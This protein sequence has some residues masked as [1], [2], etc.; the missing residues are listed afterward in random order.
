MRL[1]PWHCLALLVLLVLAA[2]FPSLRAGF[3]SVDDLKMLGRFEAGGPLDLVQ[4]FFPQNKRFYYRPL[5]TLTYIFDRDAWGTIPSFM[6]L[7]NILLHLGSTLLVYAVTRRLACVYR[8]AGEAVPFA[9][10]LLFALH[11]LAA[12]PVCWIS[13]RTDL[14]AGLFA[15]LTVWLL[16][17]G[18]NE[19]RS[20]LFALA[21][22]ALLLSCLSK[23]IGVFLL[24]GLLWLAIFAPGE[25]GAWLRR[26]RQRW[27]ALAAPAAAVA[28]YFAM[29]TVAV[30]RDTGIKSAVKGTVGGD[31]DLLDKGRIALKVYGFYL[32]KLFVP[33]PLNFGIVEVADGYVALGVLL[34]LLL[35]WCAVRRDLL[36]AFALLAFCALSPAILVP[37][38]KMAWTPFAERYLYVPLAFLAP[39]AAITLKAGRARLAPVGERAAGVA[40]VGLLLVFFA[41]TLHRAWIWQDNLR[42]YRDTVA[43]S[44]NFPA[45]KSELA[46]ALNRRGEAEEARR[47]LQEIRRD[48]PD[49]AFVVGDINLARMH[50]A[51]EEYAE[52]SALLRKVLDPKNKRY[53][54]LLQEL[55]L[56]N[57]MRWGKAASVDEKQALDRESLAWLYEQQRIQPSNFTLYRIGKQHM[58]LG[59]KE[60]AIATLRRV[61]EEAP[62]DA[63]YR[64]PA[65]KMIKNLEAR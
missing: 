65:L 14:L 37:F 6:H 58:R 27:L 60:Q 34:V 7:E 46:S 33:W 36:G 13:G 48:N 8:L 30:A 5:T 63:Y 43:K 17:A 40:F 39:V 32:K 25:E 54:A 31:F 26:L 45:A 18:L 24:P 47:L 1:K 42:L 49:S 41:S 23:E 2:Y 22:P 4:H 52:A 15:L 38:G 35:L 20:W 55:I 19:R 28:V 57:D 9:G 56:I 10:A 61:Y 29:R 44:P 64:E 50:M 53:H 11:P 3:N 51:K 21:G 16:L 62:V 12:E 59:D